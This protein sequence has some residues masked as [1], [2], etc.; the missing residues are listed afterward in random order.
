M[1]PDS[2]F[3][4]LLCTICQL[5]PTW[6]INS[7]SNYYIG[8][9]HFFHFEC[10]YPFYPKLLLTSLK[11]YI[12]CH[13]RVSGNNPLTF[14]KEPSKTLS[15]HLSFVCVCL[16]KY[17]TLDHKTSHKGPFFK[18]EVYITSSW[19]NKL[20]I[21]VWFV[22][23]GQY[24]L[25]YNYLNIWNLRVQKYENIEKI[26]FK[27]V[28]IKYLAMHVTNPKIK[29]LYIYGRKFTKYLNL[30]LISWWFWA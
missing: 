26:A 10:V 8:C 20:S 4:C 25:R 29:F 30:Y 6:F 13:Y 28:Q 16:I 2:V 12:Y 24:L 21:D 3:L 9:F 23:I 15:R 18:I 22:M 19:I 27:V 14:I 1:G 7:V 11:S 17:V 5:N